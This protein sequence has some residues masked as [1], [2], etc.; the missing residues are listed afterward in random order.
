MASWNRR[1]FLGGTMAAPMLGVAGTRRIGGFNR[2]R[3]PSGRCEGCRRHARLVVGADALGVPAA[4]CRSH[5]SQSH[6]VGRP[7]YSGGTPFDMY[8]AMLCAAP[9]SA[10]TPKWWQCSISIFA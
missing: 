4:R 5:R 3:A 7:R 8:V 1:Q 9:S 2:G 10:S 6:S